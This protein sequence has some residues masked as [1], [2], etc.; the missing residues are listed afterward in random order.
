MPGEGTLD[1]RDC[2]PVR[3]TRF[4]LLMQ[5]PST[6]VAVEWALSFLGCMR[7]MV[8]KPCIVLDIDGTILLNESDGGTRCVLHFNSLCAACVQHDIAVFCVTARQEE[9]VNRL[10]TERQLE[11]CNITPVAHTYMRPRNADYGSYKY[12]A[13]KSIATRGYSVLLTIGDQFADIS[14][15]DPPPEIE[16]DKTY[17]GQMGDNFQFGVKLPSEFA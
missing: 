6:S 8:P 9:A 11:K 14:V 3:S 17:V 1:E 16:D 5:V 15:K 12:R 13:R 4:P 2:V 10:Y 7:L